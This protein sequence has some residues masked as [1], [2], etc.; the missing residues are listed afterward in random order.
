MNTIDKN[1][2]YFHDNMAELLKQYKDKVL[3]IKDE[4]V[5]G[6]FNDE[7]SAYTD[8]VSKYALGTFLIQKCIPEKEATQT[9]HSRA[10]F[11]S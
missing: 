2:Q 6:V 9:F 1:Y 5:V 4:K 10:V 8:S 3:V 11:T 7:A